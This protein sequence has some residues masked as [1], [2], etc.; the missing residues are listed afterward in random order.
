[1]AKIKIAEIFY[2]LQGEGLYTGV[3]SVFVRTFGCN[4]ECRSFGL[5]D[6][7]RTTEPEEFAE[8]F[9]QNPAWDYTMLPLAKTGCDSYASWHKGF[10][11]LSPVME[12][13]GIMF[14]M[15]KARRGHNVPNKNNGGTHLVITGGEPLLGWQ[16]AY[17]ELLE[18]ARDMG[19]KHVT[20]ET[21]G[22]QEITDDFSD[23]LMLDGLKRAK[24]RGTLTFSVSPKLGN[25]GESTDDALKPEVVN[26]YQKYGTV[27]LKFVIAKHTD[28]RDVAFFVDKYRDAGFD[29]EV[30]LMP[31]GGDP[32]MYDVTAPEVANIAMRY[33]Y[34]YRPRL[35]VD[36][37]KN[38][39]GT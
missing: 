25:S 12:V 30:Y 21:N 33:G 39:W 5:D 38:E 1:M 22:T 3:P 2:S 20:F 4:F 36:L 16:R 15:E 13:D 6:G 18:K 14:E 7:K 8:Q 35:Q 9:K 29:G 17:P 26:S 31:C 32:E 34:R 10:K 24:N 19:Y 23:Y 28:M 11:K 27:Y 37:W